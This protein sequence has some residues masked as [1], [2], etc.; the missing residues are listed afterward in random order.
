MGPVAMLRPP[1]GTSSQTQPDG[2]FR[3]FSFPFLG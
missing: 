3:L 2:R 1:P